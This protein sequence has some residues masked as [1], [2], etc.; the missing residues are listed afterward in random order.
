LSTGRRLLAGVT[1]VYGAQLVTVV[2]QFIY[3]AVTSRSVAPAG[4][5][6][7][8]VALS[9]TGLVS[10]LATGGLGQ[11]VSRMV[12]IQRDRLRSLVTYALILGI[13]GGSILFLSAPLWAHLWGVDSAIPPIRWLA[14]SSVA[15]PF[16]GLS[17]GLM[18]RLGRFRQLALITVASNVSGM[19]VG[20]AAVLTWQSASSLVISSAVAQIAILC[21]SLF[22]T[23]RH[24]F[25]LA[26]LKHGRSDI[27]YSGK[28]TVASFLA[29][30]TGNITK[31]SMTRG[32]D[33][34]SLGYW[35]RAEVLTSLPL[36]QIQN[37][38]IRTVYPEFRHDIADSVRAKIVWT[39]MLILIAWIAL[40]LSAGVAILVP[41]LVPFVFGDGW[42]TAA[43]LAGP[44]AI[45]GGLQVVSTLLSSAIEALG[46]FRWIWSTDAILIAI[47]V[48]AA[49]FIFVYKNMFLAVIALLVT[50]VVRHGWQ[51]WMAGRYGYLDVERLL[52][53]YLV[54]IISSGLVAAVTWS[55]LELILASNGAHLYWLPT[56]LLACAVS[57]IVFRVRELLPVVVLARRYGF[58][59]HQDRQIS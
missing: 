22:A 13:V 56:I 38:L 51:V 53:Q 48:I 5:G 34:A 28:L 8:A 21:C 44:L 23:D 20:A 40:P 37:A 55:F 3:A 7:Y 2:V 36:Q 27:G 10:L 43:S 12:D 11:T 25:G 17:T 47:Q 39:D 35:N 31:L 4:F 52:R 18:V 32:I 30:L 15:S 26:K 14:I 1:W 59:R 6:A 42:E 45:V 9:V 50:N 57:A 33:A 41:P 19:M 16:L 58:L 29:Y 54:A 24:L 49:V 46:R